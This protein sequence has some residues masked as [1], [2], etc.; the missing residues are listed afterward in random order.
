M[1]YSMRKGTGVALFERDNGPSLKRLLLR[2]QRRSQRNRFP[3]INQVHHAHWQGKRGAIFAFYDTQI[4][5]QFAQ[6][7][8]W[9][10][11][12]VID[13]FR[14]DPVAIRDGEQIRAFVVA[15]CQYITMQRYGEPLLVHF[16]EEERVAGYSLCQLIE[17]SDITAHFI[18]RVDAVCLSIFSCASYAPY[19]A[20]AFCQE[21]F[22][23]QEV[24][25]KVLFRGP[26]EGEE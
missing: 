19:G 21:W 6:E 15:L 11:E 13:L 16:G 12:T 4:T 3:G 20:A 26:V 22:G 23:A 1:E 17:T 10:M 25:A 24:R 5:T 8:P 18:E 9:G 14:C 7:Q 2:W